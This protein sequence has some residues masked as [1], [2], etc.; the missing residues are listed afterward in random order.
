VEILA[1]PQGGLGLFTGGTQGTGRRGAGA[2][3]LGGGGLGAGGLAAGAEPLPDESAVPR[4]AGTARRLGQRVGAAP[5]AGR[6]AAGAPLLGGRSAAFPGGGALA[7]AALPGEAEIRIIADETSNA[8]VILATPRDYRRVESALRKLD[9]V[10]LQ[11]LIEA[12]IA[13]VTLTDRL[14]YGLQ[15]FFESGDF[16][17]TLS[18]A[19]TG[20]VNP[21]FPGFSA[22]VSG[23]DARVVL[24][25]LASITDLNVIS[26]PQ[27]LVIDNQTAV[28]QVGDQ[29]PIA[30][31]QVIGVEDPDAPVR[32]SIEYRDTG[33]ILLVTPRVNAGGLVTLEVEQEI[34]DAVQTVTSGLE[35]P[36]IQ[37]RLVQTTVAVQSGETLALGGLIRDRNERT[38]AG[39]PLL[40][41][42]PI[43]GN[44]FRRNN[45]DASRTEILILITPRVVRNELDAR[46]VTNELR[47]RMRTIAPLEGRVGPAPL[48][49]RGATPRT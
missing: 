18:N 29:V 25:A 1:G 33:T 36:T 46:Q 49:P 21:V 48:A 40:M 13:E 17:V 24:N 4:A 15:W 6:A 12:T 11:V 8:L 2:G 14:A 27:L 38:R 45:N 42:I 35:S 16:A 47:Q 43:L 22:I 39:V 10:P 28:L 41:D 23:A 34:S 3:G 37:R 9:I 26:A 7:G 20:A 44:L 5:G 31:Q 30:T 32:N 19:D